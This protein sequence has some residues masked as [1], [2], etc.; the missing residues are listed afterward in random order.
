[1]ID[2]KAAVQR[3]INYLNQLHEFIPAN[4]VRLEETEYADSGD[5]L[6]TLSA[7]TPDDSN[8]F[9]KALGSFPSQKRTYKQ[10][11]IDAASGD[12]KSMK[13]RTLE[14]IE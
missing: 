3:A 10:F 7:L 14:P 6:I 13:V 1:M 2:V 4:D 8:T 9:V 11:R 12:V 5:W